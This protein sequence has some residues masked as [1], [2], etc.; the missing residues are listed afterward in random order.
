LTDKVIA[1]NPVE[2]PNASRSMAHDREPPPGYLERRGVN[3]DI[4]P[5]ASSRDEALKVAPYAVDLGNGTWMPFDSS[6]PDWVERAFVGKPL[7]RRPAR[8]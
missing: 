6:R 3:I 7:H 1:R 5:A 2:R 8:S 4:K